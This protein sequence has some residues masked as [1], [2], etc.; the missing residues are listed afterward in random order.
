MHVMPTAILPEAIEAASRDKN[1]EGT[2]FGIVTFLHKICN[3]LV[4]FGVLGILGVV[5]YV[6]TTQEK[7]VTQPASAISAIRLLLV[8]VPIILLL[9]GILSAV[10]FKVGRH[11]QETIQR[12]IKGEES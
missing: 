8:I 7:I 5:G 6:E 2:H 11:G 12:P 10:L 3:S 9:L 1:A 4:Q